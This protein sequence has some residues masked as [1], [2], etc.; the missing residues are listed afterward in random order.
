VVATFGV[1]PE[2]VAVVPN[3]V[4]TDLFRPGRPG[5]RAPRELL[6][7][8]RLTAQKNVLTAVEAM[9]SLPDVTLRIVGSGELRADLERR[10]AELRLLN[11]CLEGRVAPATLVA[12]Y[13]R[14]TAVLMPSSHEGLPLVLLEAMA[15]GAPV[16][17]SALPELM[18]I[19]GD[20][21]VTVDPLTAESLAGSIRALLD[22]P[23]RQERLSQ[24]ACRRAA[25][26]AWPAVA[27]A[28]DEVYAQLGLEVS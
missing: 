5:A 21:V 1:K 17:C 4:D 18:E 19:G 28:V 22:D 26:Y 11:V 16:V 20:A 27:D 3:G 8:G 25:S 9:A 13:Q 7:V 24:A 23:G 2:R 15:A 10:I 6:F 12:Y 14:A